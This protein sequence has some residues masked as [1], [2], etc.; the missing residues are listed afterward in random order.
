MIDQDNPDYGATATEPISQ[1][2]NGQLHTCPMNV[3]RMGECTCNPNITAEEVAA[4]A[5]EVRAYNEKLLLT[6]EWQEA[7][8]RKKERQQE[9]RE[10]EDGGGTI[11]VIRCK[12][13]GETDEVL[14][15]GSATQLLSELCGRC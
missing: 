8:A 12:K 5:A 3:H 15:V 14:S 13:C 10:E 2:T 6:P 4:S 9:L 7:E 11:L 1:P